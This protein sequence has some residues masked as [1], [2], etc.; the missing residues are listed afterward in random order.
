MLSH[1]E[2]YIETEIVKVL[3]P[4]FIKVMFVPEIPTRDFVHI[5]LQSHLMISFVFRSFKIENTK[6]N[7]CTNESTS[8]FVHSGAIPHWRYAIMYKAEEKAVVSTGL[9]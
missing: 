8:Y 9:H 6:E 5:Y 3:Q 7:F 2:Y 1:W 4:S